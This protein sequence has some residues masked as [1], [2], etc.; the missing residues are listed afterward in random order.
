MGYL[1]MLVLT[2]FLQE[3]YIDVKCTYESSSHQSPIRRFP[4]EC[5]E[6]MLLQEDLY[7]VCYTVGVIRKQLSGDASLWSYKVKAS[8]RGRP[9]EVG[10]VFPLDSPAR[11]PR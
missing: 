9:E 3:M 5:E 11:R 1:L 10:L 6:A 8:S 2:P 4:V 7:K